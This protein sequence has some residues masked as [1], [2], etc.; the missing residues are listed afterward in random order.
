MSQPRSSTNGLEAV[1]GQGAKRKTHHYRMLMRAALPATAS[2]SLCVGAIYVLVMIWAGRADWHNILPV[3]VALAAIPVIAV[4]L[5]IVAGRRSHP[6][7]LALAVTVFAASLAISIIA[8]T[9]IPVSFLGIVLGLPTTLLGVTVANLAMARS[10]TRRVGLLDFP[11]A[12]E[13]ARRLEGK[14]PIVTPET[15][16][17]EIRRV[18]ID[19]QFHH[20]GGW[21]PILTRLYLRGFEIEGWPSY[22]EGFS[23][24]VDIASFD[25]ADVSYSPSQILYYRAKRLVDIVG[26]LVLA[27]PALLVGGLLW[28]YIRLVD[29]GPS[30]FIQPRRGYGGGVFRLYKFR[31]MVKNA[32]TASTAQNDA[33]VLP[34]CHIV[35]QLRI[36]ELPQLINILKGEMSFIGPRPVSVPIAEAL[37]ARLPQYANRSIL[38][39]GLTGWAQ[40]SH[41]YAETEDEEITKLSYDL[42]YLKHVS[43]DLDVIIAVR[44]IKTLLFRSGAR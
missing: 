30:L 6:F 2:A 11:E 23:G 13:V 38:L 43:F 8:A 37:E 40:V 33:R 3:A 10:L 24:R 25:L 29:G 4:S 28:L 14:V 12:P 17:P 26:V 27:G 9:R 15:I 21:G 18:L 7:T 44:T 1:I 36:D 22:L 19:P 39:P 20:G 16:G 42:F 31:T 5:L 32:D 35:R 34:G 41:G